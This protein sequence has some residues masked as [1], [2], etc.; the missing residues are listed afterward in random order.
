[1]AAVLIRPLPTSPAS[2][3]LLS[4][5]AGGSVCAFIALR[6]RSFALRVGASGC[7]ERFEVD[8]F[9][10]LDL[11]EDAISESLEGRGEATLGLLSERPGSTSCFGSE[12]L[13]AME[14]PKL[15]AMRFSADE[16]S[17]SGEL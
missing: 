10:G 3:W 16:E 8:E 12:V 2:T 13:C 5:F 7:G 6:D 9:V 14:E 11:I 17:V 4:K 15:L 1:M